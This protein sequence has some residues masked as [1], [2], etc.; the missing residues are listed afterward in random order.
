MGAEIREGD[1]I[2]W[3]YT[4][5]IYGD[6]LFSQYEGKMLL[7]VFGLITPE[8]TAL[9]QRLQDLGEDFQWTIA[10]WGSYE[11]D[12]VEPYRRLHS[13]AQAF[14]F[15]RNGTLIYT[16]NEG[17]DFGSQEGRLRRIFEIPIES[18]HIGNEWHYPDWRGT[19]SGGF[20]KGDR[21]LNR[22]HL[23][24][25]PTEDHAESYEALLQAILDYVCAA[26]YE[27]DDDM[28]ESFLTDTLK[29]LNMLHDRNSHLR[30]WDA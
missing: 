27:M 11:W 28:R 29:S 4:R 3:A 30:Y 22:T 8:L 24:P 5:G 21:P 14:I 13:S 10:S 23:Y 26:M 18:R 20:Q 1:H 7:V 15:S 25:E 6:P 12:R 9:C 17:E 19:G 2:P 16:L